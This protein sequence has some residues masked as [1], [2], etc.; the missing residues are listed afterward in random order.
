MILCTFLTASTCLLCYCFDL[1]VY[2]HYYVTIV[3]YLLIKISNVF[4]VYLFIACTF[5]LVAFNVKTKILKL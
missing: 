3:V 5:H 1:S 4:S 2:F